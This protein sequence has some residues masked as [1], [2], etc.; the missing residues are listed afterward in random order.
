M[1][2]V[3]QISKKPFPTIKLI[4]D[5]TMVLIS[6]VSCLIAVH[7]PGSVG[8]GTVAAAFLVGLEV[9]GLTGIWGKSR[10]R[11]MNKEQMK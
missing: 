2:V 4:C 7:S 9:K 10:N 6:L 5:V 3:S 8:V 1:V 11:L